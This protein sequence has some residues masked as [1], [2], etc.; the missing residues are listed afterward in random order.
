MSGGLCR[1]LTGRAGGSCSEQDTE[2][3]RESKNPHLS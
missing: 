2:P 3:D 1:P